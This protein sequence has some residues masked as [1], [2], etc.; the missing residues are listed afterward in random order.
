MVTGQSERTGWDLVPG[1]PD[2]VARLQAAVQR[3]VHAYL[4]VG[5][6]GSGKRVALRAFAGE[7]FAADATGDDVDRHRRLASLGHHPDLVVVE[8]EGAMFRGGRASSDG[9]TEASTV[10]RE[11]HRSPVEANRKIVAA[12]AFHTANDTAIGALLK[13]IEE[14]PGRTIVVLL[15]ESIPANQSAIASRCVTIE[16]H[17]ISP[18]DLEEHLV[19]HGVARDAAAIAVAASDGN[20][21]RAMVLATDQRLALRID[22]WRSVPMRLDGSGS[23]ATTMA[24]ELLAMLDDALTPVTSANEAELATF[25]EEVERYGMTGV[26]GRRNALKARHKRIERQS[27]VAE[28]RLG[29]TTLAGVYRDEAIVHAHPAPL[30]QAIDDILATSAAFWANPNEQLALTALFLSLPSL[31]P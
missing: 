2:A 31:R 4:F 19:A 28:L 22:A 3:P 14:P 18:I 25:E 29:L 11:A 17:P 10:I 23:A 26:T 12:D 15:A 16:F 30:L 20:L 24:A 13:T 9:E 6:P 5:P 21:D 8:P 27:R 1:Q 7:L